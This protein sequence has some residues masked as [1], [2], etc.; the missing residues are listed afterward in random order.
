MDVEKVNAFTEVIVNT[1]ETSLS[2]IPFRHGSFKRLTGDLRNPDDLMG[3]ITFS[4]PLVGAVIFTFPEDTAKKIYSALMF[5]EIDMLN[6]RLV[7]AYTEIFKL[8]ARNFGPAL[9]NN[10]I[11]FDPPVVAAGRRLKFKNEDNVDWLFIPMAFKNLG[12]FNLFIGLKDAD[13]K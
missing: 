13:V 11:Q 7:N 8:M 2:Q 6:D 12:R 4:G 3:I 9:K 1:F 5:E 10:D